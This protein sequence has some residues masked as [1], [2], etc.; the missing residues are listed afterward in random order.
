MCGCV[1]N[2]H[3]EALEFA[4][5][6][7]RELEDSSSLSADV[8]IYAVL[9][10]FP[11]FSLVYIFIGGSNVYVSCVTV[12]KNRLKMKKGQKWRN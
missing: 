6:A 7:I 9:F 11:Y 3:R 5:L 4:G 2:R 1:L 12:T 8:G 10:L